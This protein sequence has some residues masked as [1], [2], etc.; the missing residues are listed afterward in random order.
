VLEQQLHMA[1]K[2]ESGG[3]ALPE[4]SRTI[5]ITFW[6]NIATP[7]HE[8]ETEERRRPLDSQEIEKAGQRCVLPLNACCW[9]QP[10]QV[11]APAILNLNAADF[12][13]W[14]R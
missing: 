10:Q 7:S 1:V 11:L 6:R 5:S 3:E 13:I 14:E 2:M 4:G 9:P 12:R 8:A